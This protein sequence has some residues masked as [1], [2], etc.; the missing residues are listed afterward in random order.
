MTLALANVA[1]KRTG[2]ILTGRVVLS[3][4]AALLI[5]P[6]A[7]VVPLPDSATWLA[8]LTA[9][10]AHFFY[11]F[12]LVQAMQRGDLSLVFPVMRGTAPL[13]T[14]AAAILLLGERLGYA[15]MAGLTIATLAVIG[16]ALPPKGVRFA[17]HPDRTALIFAGLTAIGIALYNVADARG[18][19]VAP[20]PTTFIVWLFMVDWICIT[21]FALLRR[22]PRMLGQAA[23]LHW[24]HGVAA[25]ALSILSFGAALYGYSLT[26]TAKISALRETSVVFAAIIGATWLGE[27]FGARRIVF[28]LIMVAGLALMQFG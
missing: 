1:V 12:C 17:A 21:T 13:L 23:R 10:P 19:R 9:I 16:F 8:L 4:S 24:R 5:S 11:Q 6:F 26:E 18:V 2:D 14:A 7:F 27:G 20:Q 25:G 3:A 15:E 28:A 22:G